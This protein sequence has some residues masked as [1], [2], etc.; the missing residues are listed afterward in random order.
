[1]T[2]QSVADDASTDRKGSGDGGGAREKSVDEILAEWDREVAASSD[3]DS[4][5]DKSKD[6]SG[7]DDEIRM[8]YANRRVDEAMTKAARVAAEAAGG[9][10]SESVLKHALRGFTESNQAA[11]QAYFDRE[12]NP[13][14]WRELCRAFGRDMA[15]EMGDAIDDAASSSRDAV[16]TAVRG[17][18]NKVPERDP[19]PAMGRMSNREFEAMKQELMDGER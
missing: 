19:L 7:L 2:T 4:G 16:D 1:M 9:K 14:R 3:T 6:D 15:K 13:G 5:A 11:V 8:E 10:I 18:S 17:A 12:K